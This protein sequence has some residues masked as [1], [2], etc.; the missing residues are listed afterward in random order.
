MIAII[1]YKAGNLKS[2]ERALKSL[3]F[4][5]RITHD[6]KEIMKAERIVFPGV[7]AAGS[8]IAD[9]KELRLD[10]VLKETFAGGMPVLGICMGAQIILRWSEE[11]QTQCLG[12]IR[13]E[14][15][16]FPSPLLS[17]KG[18]RLKIPH[19]GWNSVRLTRSHPV[20]KDIRP[21]DEFYFVHSYYPFP[22]SSENV[23]GTTEYGL[24]FPS[25]IGSKNLIATQ[26]HPE[27][28]GPPGLRILENFCSW[29]GQDAE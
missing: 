21:E 1:D 9:L 15:K 2:V 22:S 3:G 10:K 6:K 29:S 20:C 5:C 23:L 4:S 16:R 24:N 18:E 13:G 19:M 14:A 28:S 7:G 26:F 25:I 11:N 27:K 12:L 8:A 17:D